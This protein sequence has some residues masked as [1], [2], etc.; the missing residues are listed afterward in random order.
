MHQVYIYFVWLKH[1][2]VT[3]V[4]VR[5]Y[6]KWRRFVQRTE[7]NYIRESKKKPPVCYIVT[8]CKVCFNHS[9]NNMNFFLSRNRG[10]GSMWK[11]NIHE[12]VYALVL[13]KLNIKVIIMIWLRLNQFVRIKIQ[14]S[15]V[16]WNK[17]KSLKLSESS[18]AF[19]L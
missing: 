7:N 12:K 17:K 6:S 10:V 14:K 13:F 4:L 19:L 16:L 18:S 5:E 2:S 15:L 11:G 9:I 1:D 3:C 8:S